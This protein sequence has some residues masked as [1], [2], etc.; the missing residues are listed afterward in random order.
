[1]IPDNNNRDKFPLTSPWD[2]TLATKCGDVDDN[3]LVNIIDLTYLQ[4]YI[5][6]GGDEPIYLCTGD[7]NGDTLVNIVDMTYLVC[8]LFGG[9]PEPEGCCQ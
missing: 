6:G 3:G 8:Y 7:V 5:F 1:M 9:G 4:D 2:G